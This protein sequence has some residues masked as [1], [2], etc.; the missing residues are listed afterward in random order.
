MK[1]IGGDALDIIFQQ[2][3]MKCST[4]SKVSKQM[5]NKTQ[6]GDQHFTDY[7]INNITTAQLINLS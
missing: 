2:A 3:G 1:Q 4:T 7:A 5:K 6:G